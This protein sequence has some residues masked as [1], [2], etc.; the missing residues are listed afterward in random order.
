MCLCDS[1]VKVGP[2]NGIALLE[3]EATMT[4]N[5]DA[6]CAGVG[7]VG[8]ERREQQLTRPLP[9]TPV[10]WVVKGSRWSVGCMDGRRS[11]RSRNKQVKAKKTINDWNYMNG[12]RV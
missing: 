5:G 9:K 11:S 4:G 2:G 8:R 7:K 12:L 1:G 10:V 3:R 6:G